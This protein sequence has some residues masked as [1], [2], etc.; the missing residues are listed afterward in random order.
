MRKKSKSSWLVWFIILLVILILGYL[1][2]N[3]KISKQIACIYKGGSWEASPQIANSW[4]CRIPYKDANKACTSGKDCQAGQCLARQEDFGKCANNDC[5]A[6]GY[7]P[8]K[9]KM[10]T[11]N[12]VENGVIKTIMTVY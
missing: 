1:I 7:C 8:A 6:T 10:G 5:K 4:G 3:L 2:Y 11:A 12:V 9:Y